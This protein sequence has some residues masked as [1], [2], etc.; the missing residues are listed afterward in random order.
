MRHVPKRPTCSKK[1]DMFQKDR[2]VPKNRYVPKNRHIQKDRHVQK[3]K[4]LACSKDKPT[5]NTRHTATNI[6]TFEIMSFHSIMKQ[7]L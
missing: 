6:L 4:P 1:T 3:G 2:H 5:R 7:K